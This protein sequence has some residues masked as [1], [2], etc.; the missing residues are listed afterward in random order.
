MRSAKQHQKEEEAATFS[1]VLLAMKHHLRV[2]SCT[3]FT[4]HYPV[5]TSA[6][7]LAS[8][9][10]NA[11]EILNQDLRSMGLPG[12]ARAEDMM[13]FPDGNDRSVRILNDGNY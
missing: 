7:V 2:Y 8:N 5:G 12:D 1:N 3:G 10:E 13:P 9:K 11:A 6:L 4:G